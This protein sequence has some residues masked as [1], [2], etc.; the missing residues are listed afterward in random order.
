[1][2]LENMPED[3]EIP[4]QLV[5]VIDEKDGDFPPP[6]MQAVRRKEQKHAANRKQTDAELMMETEHSS[7][8]HSSIFH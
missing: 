8:K 2:K 4:Q 6:Q 5:N 1:V 7:N 3:A